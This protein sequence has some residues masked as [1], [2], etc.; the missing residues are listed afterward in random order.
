MARTQDGREAV[1]YCRVSTE[2]QAVSGLGLEAQRQRIEA[3]AVA[4]G[5][6]LARVFTD[7]GISGATLDRPALANL[8]T[9]ADAGRVEAVYTFAFSRMS[10]STRDMLALLDRFTRRGVRLVSLS[11]GFDTRSA[12]GAFCLTIFAALSELERK[13][14]AERTSAALQAK[15][16]RGERAGTT[17]YGYAAD[18]AGRL[19]PSADE[20]ATIRRARA[21]RRRGRTLK[22]IAAR[23]NG[24]GRRTRRG[25]PWSPQGVAQ[26][27]L[28]ARERT[29]R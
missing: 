25:A 5:V 9:Q 10:R 17:P 3:R 20:R 19:V 23:L 8:L 2:G 13:Q 22:A 7:D 27:L 14:I 11:E 18:S 16:A 21:L 29:L 6:Q 12:A 1:G 26:T 15:L 28:K 4:D 24:E